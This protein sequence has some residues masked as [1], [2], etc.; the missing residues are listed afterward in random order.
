MSS[1]IEVVAEKWLGILPLKYAPV[2]LLILAAGL[3]GTYPSLNKFA[4]EDGV[5]PFA[6]TFWFSFLGAVLCL[7]V[8]LAR[9]IRPGFTGMHLKAYAATGILGATIPTVTLAYAAPNLPASV[10][11]LILSLTP[12]TTYALALALRMDQLRIVSITGLLLGLCGVV[13]I[14]LPEG[15]LP[16]GSQVK[17]LLLILA[18]PVCFAFSNIAAARYRP[19]ASPSVSLAFGLLITGALSILPFMLGTGSYYVPV[20]MSGVGSWAVL[21]LACMMAVFICLFFEIV[22]MAGPVFFAQFNYLSMIAGIAWATILFH[23]RPTMWFFGAGG[24]MLA[25]VLL[26]NAGTRAAVR[27]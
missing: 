16:R 7:L 8:C 2:V 20:P 15:A 23:E 19:P 22:R 9:G 6:Y 26:V 17:W 1:S 25:G 13:L 10:V 24:L 5:P 27:Q 12:G 11:S 18:T 3:Y 21:G 4:A 14:V